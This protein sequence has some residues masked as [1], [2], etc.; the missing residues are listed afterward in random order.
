MTVCRSPIRCVGS[1][2]VSWMFYISTRDVASIL[3]LEWRA[4]TSLCI[5]H[6]VPVVATR[7]ECLPFLNAVPVVATRV[8]CL[9]FLHAVPVVATRVECLP[10]L[11]AVPVVATRVECLPFLNAVPVVAT[12]VECLPFLNAVP[13][14]ATRVECLPFLPGFMSAASATNIEHG[15]STVLIV[16]FLSDWQSHLIFFMLLVLYKILYDHHDKMYM[17]RYKLEI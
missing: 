13:V 1:L 15:W 2:H 8:E 9:A 6:A 17:I 14:V 5:L 12:R 3:A 11:N 4:V 10:F 7:V 16:C